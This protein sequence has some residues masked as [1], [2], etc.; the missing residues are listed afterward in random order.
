MEK[1]NGSR[2]YRIGIRYQE[3][4]REREDVNGESELWNK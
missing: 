4:K 1:E 2:W 3:L